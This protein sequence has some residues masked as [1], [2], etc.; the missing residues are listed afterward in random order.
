MSSDQNSPRIIFEPPQEDGPFLPKYT[1]NLTERAKQ[2][3]LDPVI[4]RDSEVRRV[5]QILSRRTKNNPVLIGDPGVGK[6]AIVE[7]LAQRIIAGDVPESLKNRDLLVLDIA[8]LLA[9]AKYRG[10]FEERLKNVVKE[11]EDAA[12]KYILFIDEL[13]TIVGAGASEGAVDAG[14]MMKPSLARGT[15]RVIGATTIDEYRKHIEK[16]AALERR[17]QPVL[18]NEPSIEDT[19]AILRGIK[20]KYEVHHGIR[21]TDDAVVAAAKLSARYIPDRFLPDKAIDLIDEATSGL[22]I[23]TE[24]SPV[25]L[26]LKKRK[27]TQMEIELAGLKR[28]K[29]EAVQ[30]RKNEL[31]AKVSDLKKEVSALSKEWDI[32]KD[33]LKKL[34]E[35]R[36]KMDLLKT[37][38]ERAERDVDLNHAAEIKYGKMPQLLKEL[39]VLESEWK[40]IPEDKRVLREEVTDEDIAEV[41]ARWTGI[42][43]TKLLSTEVEK[44]LHLEDELANRVVGQEEGI[45]AVAKAL[46]RN[47]AGLTRREGPIGSFLFLGPTGVGKTE[48]AKALAEFMMG[49]EDLI[50]RIDMSEYQEDHSIARLIGSPPGYVGYEEGGQLTEAVRRKP[51]SVVLLD[52]IEKANPKIYNV[53]L[54]V[55]DDG[56]LTDGQGRVVNFKNTIIIM[57]S[58]IEP[59]LLKKAFRP[60]FLN[61]LDATVEYKSLSPQMMERIVDIQL[62]GVRK[63]LSEQNVSLTVTQKAK[64]Y[65]AQKGYD[66]D[67]GARPLRRLIQNEVLDELSLLLIENKLVAGDGVELDI[68]GGVLKIHTK[69]KN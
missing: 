7:G 51:Y 41:I 58:N 8:T 66:P 39:Q 4:G 26:D 20:E 34:Q 10:D 47:R 29:G 60:E 36:K 65:L 52:E 37:D 1:T 61:R 53:M 19:I 6:T 25:S 12:G 35:G 43:V 33:I 49:S 27:I 23:E 38:L 48:T 17:F 64:T 14:N 15:L 67:F 68:V 21:I 3:K 24:S 44:L 59:A 13:H 28:E 54:Q 16:D 56:R 32:Q 69:L 63:I 22:K 50:I 31:E 2:N 46:K 18:V 55:L 11:V 5:M 30:I 42:P 57:T 45:S 62:D 9:G 40:Q